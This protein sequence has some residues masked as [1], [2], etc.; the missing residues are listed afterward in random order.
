MAAAPDSWKTPRQNFVREDDRPGA[1]RRPRRPPGF[2]GPCGSLAE[3]VWPG[4]RSDWPSAR[5]WSRAATSSWDSTCFT[6]G[7]LK[8]LDQTM[9]FPA[10]PFLSALQIPVCGRSLAEAV[11]LIR[12]V[13]ALPYPEFAVKR[14]M[15]VPGF[16]R[17]GVPPPPSPPHRSTTGDPPT[18]WQQLA[19]SRT[20]RNCW[21][22]F[23][24]QRAMIVPGLPTL[25]Q[26]P[27]RKPSIL[28]ISLILLILFLFPLGLGGALI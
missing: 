15:L 20:A 4:L 3:P 12:F 16:C 24:H 17:S 8:F 14:V 22:S 19:G 28:L 18:F 2:S 11:G 1:T 25:L 10:N 26:M 13:P 21:P 27:A 7:L 5:P 6:S 23:L 9:A